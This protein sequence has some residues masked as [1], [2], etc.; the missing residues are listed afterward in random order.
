MAN[1]FTTLRSID[2]YRGPRKVLRPMPGVPVE[3]MSK[4]RLPPPGKLPFGER[5]V[6]L[7]SLE[8]AP[9]K[10]A[11]GRMGPKVSPPGAVICWV[12]VLG[13]QGKPLWKVEIALS[14]HPPN[15]SPSRFL[16][17]RKNGRS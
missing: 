12:K 5:K 13:V 6:V 17:S 11:I 16:R 8:P 9:P 10:Y 3:E 14:C 7:P 1:D 15:V 2:Q 4:Y